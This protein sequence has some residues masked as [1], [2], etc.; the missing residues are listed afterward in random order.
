[1][2]DSYKRGLVRIEDTPWWQAGEREQHERERRLREEGVRRLRRIELAA[3]L[4][5]AVERM[6]FEERQVVLDTERLAAPVLERLGPRDRIQ[7]LL[8]AGMTV[9]LG[10]ALASFFSAP[11]MDP[12]LA[13]Y[14][15]IVTTMLILAY[16]M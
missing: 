1:M 2:P 11:L 3:R 7:L 15:V 16:I 6:A 12:D 14:G 5:F 8:W 4:R 9:V 10:F 13:I